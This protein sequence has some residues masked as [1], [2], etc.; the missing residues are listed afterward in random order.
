[1]PF[2]PSIPYNDLPLLPPSADVVETGPILKKCIS[3]RVALAELK[4]AAE[5]IP[6]ASVL[7][8]ALRAPVLVDHMRSVAAVNPVYSGLRDAALKEAALPAGGNSVRYAANLERA[9]SIPAT[10]KFLL[11]DIA[12]ARLWMRTFGQ[13]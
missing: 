2:D 7:A 1:M 13:T 10:G 11:V 4:Q 12:T 8:N 9:R 3:A 6:N 5:L